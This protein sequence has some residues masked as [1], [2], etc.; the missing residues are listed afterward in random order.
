MMA[1]M[2][3]ERVFAEG[4]LWELGVPRVERLPPSRYLAAQESADRRILLMTE[5]DDPLEVAAF[6]GEGPS[7]G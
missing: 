2:T 3:L 5:E 1:G 7:D 4:Q 6:L